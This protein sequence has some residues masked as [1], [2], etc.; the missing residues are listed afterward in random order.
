MRPLLLAALCSSCA[1]GTALSAELTCGS[2][3]LV[4]DEP[5]CGFVDRIDFAGRTVIQAQPDSAG[6]FV[7][8]VRTGGGSLDALFP[9]AVEA[10]LVAQ[11]ERTE[12][13]PDG[14]TLRVEG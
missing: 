11:V 7:R 3:V 12:G 6:A 9:N 5:G 8:V 13:G 14:S 2:A 4:S 1:T 10:V